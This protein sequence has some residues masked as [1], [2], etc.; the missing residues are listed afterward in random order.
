MYEQIY[1][2]Q[3]NKNQDDYNGSITEE[4]RAFASC[5]F[6]SWVMHPV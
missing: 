1:L 5:N 4:K 6:N 2:I 3:T